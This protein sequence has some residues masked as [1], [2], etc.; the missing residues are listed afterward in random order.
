MG[1]GLALQ[2]LEIDVKVHLLFI[3]KHETL[4]VA[5]VSPLNVLGISVMLF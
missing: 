5:T 4:C 1:D 3:Q 2:I